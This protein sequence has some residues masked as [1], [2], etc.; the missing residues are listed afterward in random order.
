MAGTQTPWLSCVAA[1]AAMLTMGGVAAAQQASPP[2]SEAP[3]APSLQPVEPEVPPPAKA[4]A[5]TP[6]EAPATSTTPGLVG[7]NVFSSDGTR[8]GEVRAIAAGA[9]GAVELHVRTG[10]FLGFG[11]RIVAIPEGRYT[12]SGQSIRLNLDSS[13]INDLPA[14]ND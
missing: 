5:V 12:R 1:I 6:S 2:A 13:Q 4:P 10:G 3:A 9:N 11:G 8:I 14:I 7:L